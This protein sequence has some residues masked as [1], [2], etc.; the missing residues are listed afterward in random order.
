MLSRL[1][2]LDR[3][4]FM[5]LF[6]GPTP[7][8]AL[9]LMYALTVL[10]RGYVI[11]AVAT[12]ALLPEAATRML[13]KSLFT[14]QRQRIARELLFVLLTVAVLVVATKMLVQRPRPYVA[15]DLLPLGGSPP[16]DFSFPSGHS[17]GAFTFA[18]FLI[19]R[20]KMRRATIA[21]LLVTALGIAISRIYLGAHYPSDI[22]AGGVLGATCGGAFGLAMRKRDVP[23]TQELA[24]RL[25]N[26]RTPEA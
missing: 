1:A 25:A 3:Y 19:T 12:L 24:P 15:L 23:K 2:E 7:G 4:V 22:L 14:V 5:A 6:G 11:W 18:T 21:A 20:V 10:G 16:R 9:H 26:P 8:Y 13:P 17:A